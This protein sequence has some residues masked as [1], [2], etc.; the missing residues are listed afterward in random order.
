MNKVSHKNFL[1]VEARGPMEVIGKIA[2]YNSTSFGG[3]K[4]HSTPYYYV[5][6]EFNTIKG[7]PAF[8]S[9]ENPSQ[10]YLYCYRPKFSTKGGNNY[11]H[12]MLPTV[13]RPLPVNKEGKRK[14]GA[15]GFHF[16]DWE[17]AYKQ[18][19]QGSTASNLFPKEIRGQSDEDVITTLELTAHQIK[20]FDALLFFHV[21][22]PMCHPSNSYIFDDPRVPYFASV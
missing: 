6:S 8:V 2:V 22:W 9:I 21:L 20:I 17:I 3:V 15:W 12:H 16:A 18:H 19:R 1:K 4:I 11:V 5:P 14:C 7:E 13:S 10:W